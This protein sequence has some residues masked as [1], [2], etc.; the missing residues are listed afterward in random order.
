MIVAIQP[1]VSTAKP[2]GLLMAADVA[3]PLSPL[4]VPLALPVPPLPAMVEII[5]NVLGLRLG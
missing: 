1:A 3:A 2:Y 5:K 4:Y